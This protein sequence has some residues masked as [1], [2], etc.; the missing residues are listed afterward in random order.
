MTRLLPLSISVSL[1]F[2]LGDIGGTGTSVRQAGAGHRRGRRVSAV[3][4]TTGHK[5]QCGGERWRCGSISSGLG[6]ASRGTRALVVGAVRATSTLSSSSSSLFSCPLSSSLS[7]PRMH[8]HTA[9]YRQQR[10]KHHTA[11]IH[12]NAESPLACCCCRVEKL[13]DGSCD[14]GGGEGRRKGW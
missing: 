8:A 12:I 6:P 1:N 13:R 4:E 10:S 2:F 5:R 3:H 11:L 7:S 14:C 9:A